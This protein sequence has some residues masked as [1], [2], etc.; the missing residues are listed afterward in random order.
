MTTRELAAATLAELRAP[1]WRRFAFLWFALTYV[2][3][4]A[5][6]MAHPPGSAGVAFMIGL[7]LLVALLF[8][9]IAGSLLRRAA[10]SSRSPWSIDLSLLYYAALHFVLAAATWYWTPYVDNSSAHGAALT[11]AALPLVLVAPLA[12][13]LVAVAVERPLALSPWPFLK[14]ANAWFPPLLLLTLA[15]LLPLSLAQFWSSVMLFGLGRGAIEFGLFHSVVSTS[16][17][18][19]SLALALAAY[20]SVAEG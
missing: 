7:G 5:F 13:W 4:L 9:W 11:V 14:R 15:L 18:M 17:E 12:P 16:V 1:C 20:R 10:A 3:D 19:L 6:A 8:L 2:S